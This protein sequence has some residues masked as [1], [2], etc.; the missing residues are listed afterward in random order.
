MKVV[1]LDLEGILIPEIWIAF[2]EYTG[3]DDLRLTTRDI[4]NYDELMQRRL[5]ILREHNLGLGDIQT[6]IS[7]MQP[8]EG[9]EQFLDW[10][11]Q[12]FQVVLVTDSFYEFI[13]PLIRQMGYPFVLCHNLK[14][15]DN[16]FVTHY[17]LRKRDWK[18]QVVRAFHELNYRVISCGDSYNDV[19]MLEE[20][21][22]G[23]WFRPSENVAAEFPQYIVTQDYQELREA[24]LDAS[25]AF[26]P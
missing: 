25:A 21:D 9:A 19:T 6:V 3:I 18:R 7:G 8:L 15:D 10:L 17:I 11:R 20:S 22:A 13:M 12:R 5:C 16:G 23:I 26:V 1:C 24:F 14:V 4:P 2:A